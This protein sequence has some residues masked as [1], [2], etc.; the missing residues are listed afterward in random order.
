MAFYFNDKCF[1]T[2]ADMQT[3]GE[4]I[5]EP[6][7]EKHYSGEFRV[8]IPPEVHRALAEQSLTILPVAPYSPELNLIE[9]LWR[10][11]KCE[12]MPFSAY[13]LPYTFKAGYCFT[14][15]SMRD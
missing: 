15:Q 13:S 7:A 8:R 1:I 14:S 2:F 10:K 11:I 5:P 4:P 3:S 6:L 9:I 12:W